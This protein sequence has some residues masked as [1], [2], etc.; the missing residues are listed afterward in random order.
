[1]GRNLVV[2]AQVQWL[3]AQGIFLLIAAII[4]VNSASGI[5]AAITIF[6][7]VNIVYQSL[8]NVIPIRAS[9]AYAEG[10]ER[11][12]VAYLMRT[13]TI[14]GALVGAPILLISVFGRFVLT[15][16][17][18]HAYAGFASLVAW[19]GAYMWLTLVYRGLVYYHRTMDT[20]AVL[21]RSA[22]LVALVSVTACAFLTYRY[23]ATGGMA[24]LV[25]GQVLN[26]AVPLYAAIGLHR[27]VREA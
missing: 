22:V 17:F 13:G 6:G 8:E 1:M 24:A 11:S 2:V 3:G 21:A 18:G 9:R 25:M 26:V 27:K 23:G 7:P 15:L 12:L 16:V 14:L 10:G 20:A 19:E 4:G 5:R